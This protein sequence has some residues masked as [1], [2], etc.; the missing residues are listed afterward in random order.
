MRVRLASCL[1]NARGHLFTDLS[2]K[3]S[4]ALV[5]LVRRFNLSLSFPLLPRVFFFLSLLCPL[6]RSPARSLKHKQSTRACGSLGSLI[7]IISVKAI[8]RA[9]LDCV[10]PYKSVFAPF[11]AYFRKRERKRGRGREREQKGRVVKATIKNYINC[12]TSTCVGVKR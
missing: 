5:F 10:L 2:G 1:R 7:I 3:P 8:P 6:S 12:N 11:C 4:N 9:A